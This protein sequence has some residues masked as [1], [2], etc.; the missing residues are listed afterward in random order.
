[1]I[2]RRHLL[3][4]MLTAAPVAAVAGERDFTPPSSCWFQCGPYY[5]PFSGQ[6][7][8]ELDVR[9]SEY[10][11]GDRGELSPLL[12]GEYGYRGG[13]NGYRSHIRHS[14]DHH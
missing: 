4:L 7:G 13:E 12:P 5:N 11:G 14:H 3:V 1:M 8:V 9:N 6:P 10:I 2:I